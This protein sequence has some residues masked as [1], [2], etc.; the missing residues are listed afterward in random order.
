MQ[1]NYLATLLGLYIVVILTILDP[2]VSSKLVEKP[3][4]VYT[5]V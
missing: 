2:Y 1:L 5:Y 4:C 3:Y